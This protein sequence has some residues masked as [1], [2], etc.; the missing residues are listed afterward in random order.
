MITRLRMPY[1]HLTPPAKSGPPREPPKPPAQPPRSGWLW[2]IFPLLWV[3]FLLVLILVRIPSGTPA[4]H[5]SYSTFVS[6]VGVG[7]VQTVDINDK[8]AVTG[9]LKNGTKFT[10]QIPTALGTGA[11]QQQL[12]AEHVQI[13]ASQSKSGSSFGSIFVDFLPMLLII[14]FL[15]WL[16]RR[17]SRS[18]TGG[19]SAIGR[20]RAK[21]IEA[22]RPT[23]RFDDVAGYEGV[24]QEISEVVDFLRNPSRYAAAGA[25]GPRGVIMV[26]PPGTGKTLFA[27]AVAGEADVPFLSVTGSAFVEMFVGVGASR[28]RDLF[29]DARKRA[30]SIV[31]IDEIDAVGSRRAGSGNIGGNDEREQTLNQLL[32]EMDGF[33]Q[34]TGI[35]V[36]AATNRP[37]TLDPAL[38]R[39][40]RF[41]R[42][43]TVPLPN[44]AERAAI[45]R[46]HARGKTLAAD[47]DLDV[48][49]RATPGFSGADLANLVNEAA[50][51][52]VRADRV[53]IEPHDLDAARDRVLLGRREASNALLPEERHAV[54]VHESGHALVA[55]LCEHAD[56]VAKVT[57]LPT[58]M[59]LG[60]TEQ[61]PEAER[62]LYSE[63]YLTDLLAVRLGGRAAELVVFGEGSS[64]AANDL[65]GATQI[66]TRMVRDFGLS[67]ALGPVGYA[68]ASPRYLGETT[69]EPTRQPFSEQTQRIIDKEA[70]RLLREAE[71]RA[72]GLLRDHRQAL[73]RLADLLVVRETIDGSAVLEVLRQ[74]ER[75]REEA[76]GGLSGRASEALRRGSPGIRVPVE[77]H[78]SDACPAADREESTTGGDH[79]R[80]G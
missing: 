55:A 13:T 46:V 31:F 10:T 53:L 62:H 32:A 58:G 27:R 23:T 65:A 69:E 67:T 74:E 16:G 34:S 54:A 45:L 72:T 77:R 30:P 42:Q 5:L 70:A 66:A 80:T 8:G 51:N 75:D 12:Q 60:V 64:G 11:L 79:S 6:K 40:G 33:D 17:A 50:I 21:I 24:K 1:R 63:G 49:A 44:Q 4:A 26:G 15:L 2:W 61:L 18:V 48:V 73:D 28:V 41:D 39:P 71:E 20:S 76:D 47:V 38:L 52:A 36:L 59:T 3:V 9:V 7:Q 14:G 78:R 29:D 22:E 25:K 43:V 19:L 37:E 68:S 35:V 57:V 56:P